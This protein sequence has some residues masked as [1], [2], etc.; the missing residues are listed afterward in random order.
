VFGPLV[1]AVVLS[2]V[3]ELL[4]ARFPEGYLAIVGTLILLAVL[5]MP[6]GIVNLAM[7]KGWLPAGRGLL[8]Q[9]AREG[10]SVPPK[11]AP[12]VADEVKRVQA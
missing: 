12:P 2:I 8:R 7:K 9:L 10:G 4:W 5:F 11:P 6:R 1:G 3:N